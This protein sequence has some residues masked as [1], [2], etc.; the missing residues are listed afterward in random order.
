MLTKH[1]YLLVRL[2]GALRIADLALEIARL[3]LDEVLCIDSISVILRKIQEE[4]LP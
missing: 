3:I 4:Y 1:A 2:I